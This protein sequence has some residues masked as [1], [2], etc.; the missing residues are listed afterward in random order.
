MQR[1]RFMLALIA[2]TATVSTAAQQ[3]GLPLGEL[4]A[5]ANEQMQTECERLLRPRPSASELA[6][7]DARMGAAVF[8]DC[9]PPALAGLERDRT[10]QAL[11]SGDD[12]SALVLREF[13]ICGARAVREV[14]R[15]D[16]EK[17]TPLGAPP[18]YCACFVAAIDGLTD[19]Q[20][21]ADS[22]AARDNLEQRADAR[23]SGAPEPPLQLGLLA[24]IDR[25][26]LLPPRSQ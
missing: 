11:V 8:C 15:R 25:E 5:M 4:V 20:I 22:I 7:R 14:S 3:Q 2:L 24:R 13:D 1:N 26:C 10:P 23:R 17:F 21:V 18:T 16:C 9:M 12:F 6:Q 19:E